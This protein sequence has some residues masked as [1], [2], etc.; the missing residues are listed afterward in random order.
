M[1]EK[2]PFKEKQK[3][4]NIQLDFKVKFKTRLMHS[5]VHMIPGGT[6]FSASFTFHGYI[7][8]SQ[9]DQSPDG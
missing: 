3:A 8:N 6:V 4:N 5:Y 1:W 9:S 7:A 2:N